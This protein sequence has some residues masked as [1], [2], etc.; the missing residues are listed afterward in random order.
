MMRR[1]VERWAEEARREG[2]GAGAGG[3]GVLCRG[4]VNP[5]NSCFLNAV[6]QALFSVRRF[7]DM[8]AAAADVGV[9]EGA[10][11]LAGLAGLYTEFRR[12]AE[13]K[14][15]VPEEAEEA[16]A[17]EVPKKLS[18]SQKR[19]QRRKNHPQPHA[20]LPAPQAQQPL[21]RPC[22]PLRPDA[23][24][25]TLAAFQKTA[26]GR[27]EDAQEFCA[28]WLDALHEEVLRES[29]RVGVPLN[30]FR[31]GNAEEVG[32]EGA[33]DDDGG[34]WEE[35]GAGN[36]LRAVHAAAELEPSPFSLAFGGRL[37][38]VTDKRGG[39]P[40]DSVAFEPF[41][42]L[43]LQL[44]GAA[45][46]PVN[47]LEEALRETLRRRRVDGFVHGS[48]EVRVTQEAALDR[49]P[50][51]LVLHLKRF[52][53]GGGGRVEK[54]EARVPFPALFQPPRAALHAAV[55]PRRYVLRAAIVHVGCAPESGHYVAFARR[56]ARWVR[57]DD[58]RWAEVAESEVLRQR[59]YLLFYEN[60]AGAVDESDDS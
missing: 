28:F 47:G 60:V 24:A 43:P 34:G 13:E 12:G 53:L 20:R 33:E 17:E 29:R 46:R 37:R 40:Q 11:H 2:A 56:G 42:S 21:H 6:V 30:A 32:A 25:P 4:M 3:D 19:R 50:P 10:T 1:L 45:G 22:A 16:S 36:R 26:P 55:E 44:L 18:K 54:V 8:A 58:H 7:E 23:V 49:L 52:V 9:P 41:L 35:V 48:R 15:A 57:F 39:G 27:Q 31:H 14:G 59:A 51:V 5:R 38:T